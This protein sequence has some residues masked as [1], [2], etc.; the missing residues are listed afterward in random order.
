M[1]HFFLKTILISAFALL[2]ALSFAGPVKKPQADTQEIDLNISK[3]AIRDI[4]QS[5]LVY[6]SETRL[7]SPASI[8]NG[9][10]ADYERAVSFYEM[11]LT[12]VIDVR[13]DVTETLQLKSDVETLDKHGKTIE[14]RHIEPFEPIATFGLKSEF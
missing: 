3:S 12:E 13:G 9:E 5:N 11:E 1:K 4:I 8:I 7:L 10:N 14:G 6:D 2:P